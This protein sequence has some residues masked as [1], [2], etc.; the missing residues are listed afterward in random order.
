MAIPTKEA[1]RRSPH[2]G[3]H[4][5]SS[6]WYVLLTR[7]KGKMGTWKRLLTC[8]RQSFQSSLLTWSKIHTPYYTPYSPLHLAT[9]FPPRLTSLTLLQVHWPPWVCQRPRLFPTQWYPFPR[10]GTPPPPLYAC[11]LL[12]W[13]LAFIPP[14]ER[15][16]LTLPSNVILR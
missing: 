15:G 5:H 16:L 12:V 8:T 1:G 11:C 10:P 4:V 7:N 2:P 6:I 14:L 9:V 13:A 3:S